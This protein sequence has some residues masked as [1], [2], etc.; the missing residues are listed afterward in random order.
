MKNG[1]HFKLTFASEYELS[2][3]AFVA[4]FQYGAHILVRRQKAKKR[5]S[6]NILSRS[7]KHSLTFSSCHAD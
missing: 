7:R 1:D 5:F 4:R 6:L 2:S 3:P